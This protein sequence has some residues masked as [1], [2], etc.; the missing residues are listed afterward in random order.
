LLLLQISQM[1]KPEKDDVEYAQGRYM[2]QMLGLQVRRCPCTFLPCVCFKHD[3]NGQGKYML[4]VL[5]LQVRRC[6][7]VLLLVCF[8]FWVSSF[9]RVCHWHEWVWAC[10]ECMFVVMRAGYVMMAAAGAKLRA[11]SPVFWQYRCCA[12]R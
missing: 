8:S 11:D 10:G 7:G 4:Q 5:G 12:L 2:L 6:V 1:F 3:Q 9:G